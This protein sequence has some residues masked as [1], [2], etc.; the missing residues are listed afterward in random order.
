MVRVELWGSVEELKTSTGT[1]LRGNM[2]LDNDRARYADAKR[3]LSRRSPGRGPLLCATALAA[4]FTMAV[5]LTAAATTPVPQPASQ[6]D[7][8]RSIKPGDDFYGYANG[9][10]L[11]RVTIPASQP[12][13]DT[14]AMLME[15]TAQRVRD[16]IQEAA[17]APQPQGQR[18][19]E[20]RRLL[21]ELHGRERH[22]S[23]EADA[24]G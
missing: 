11:G 1:H 23:E 20:S 21:R 4:T 17:G 7:T 24:A 8:D 19:A 13:Y 5:L 6:D 12:S 14:R 16:L 18:G 15:K 2:P 9:G 3:S 22:R 10:W